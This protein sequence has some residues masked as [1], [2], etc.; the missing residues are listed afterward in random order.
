ML[1]LI[2]LYYL[3]WAINEYEPGIIDIIKDKIKSYK[4]IN[5]LELYTAVN[6]WKND[7]NKCKK[8]YGHIS[9]WNTIN[10]TK[11]SHL[12]YHHSYFNEDISRWNLSNVKEIDYMFHCAY[13]F[14]Q[15]ISNWNVSNVKNMY[16]VFYYAVSFNKNIS[17]WDVNNVNSMYGMFN[18]AKCFNQ[19]ISNWNINDITN[20]GNMFHNCFILEKYK[21]LKKE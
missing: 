17:K 13:S 14:N 16:Y 12:F 2:E 21:P 10:I 8:I 1:K 6:L 19:D 9:N 18:N 11:M 20:I 5:N 7:E 15:D 3:I 4:F